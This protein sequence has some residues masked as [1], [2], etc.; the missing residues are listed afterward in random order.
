[1]TK[2]AILN[3]VP[4][5]CRAIAVCEC[6]T[7]D[8]WGN[9]RDGYEVNDIGR[10]WTEEVPVTVTVSNFPRH[11][12]A[13]D[14]YREFPES[15]SFEARVVV[16]FEIDD[17]TIRKVFGVNCRLEVEGDDLAYYVNRERDL[18]P[19]GEIRIIG[20]KGGDDD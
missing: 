4:V 18:Y 17:Q 19:I 6:C 8:V 15:G 5:K 11:P 1:M 13:K 2:F 16:S 20:W 14:R 10:K 7:Y 12:G 9:A 3:N